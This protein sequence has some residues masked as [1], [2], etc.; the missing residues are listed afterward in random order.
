MSDSVLNTSLETKFRLLLLLASIPDGQHS[1]QWISAMDFL[2]IYGDSFDYGGT[3]LHGNSWMRFTEYA[4]RVWNIRD[5]LHE[6][7]MHGWLSAI[8][9][10]EGYVYHISQQGKSLA[11]DFAT[12]YAAPYRKSAAACYTVYGQYSG[13]E[14][15]AMIRDAGM[16]MTERRDFHD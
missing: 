3:N 1:Q 13:E 16:K 2:T 7:V 4:L 5:A 12:T 6:M 8:P 9:T 15:D 11:S 14:L 10:K